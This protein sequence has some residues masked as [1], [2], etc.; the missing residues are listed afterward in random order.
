[1]AAV[2]AVKSA[3]RRFLPRRV[4]VHRILKGPLRGVLIVTSWH[5]YPAAILGTTEVPLLEWFRTNVGAGETWLD[6]GAHYGYTALALSRLIGDGG[7]VYA[8][9]PVLGTAASLQRTRDVNRLRQLTVVPFG[10]GSDQPLSRV[11]TSVDRGMATHGQV[12]NCGTDL[13]VIGLDRLWPLINGGE[14]RV[15]GIKLDVQGMEHGTVLGMLDILRQWRPKLIIEFH[16]G[17]D[18]GRIVGQLVDV[19]Y[20]DTGLPI[21]ACERG[22]DDYLDDHSYLFRPASAF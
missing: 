21:E 17:V 2:S 7:R 4:R 3:I 18:R 8:F 6:V 20:H 9:E 1:V 14:P 16:A 13:Y 22:A 11:T 12:A 15:D 19:G 5:D 10:L